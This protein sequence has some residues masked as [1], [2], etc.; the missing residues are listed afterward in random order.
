[1]K[2][3]TSVRDCGA[4]TRKS[5]RVAVIPVDASAEPDTVGLIFVIDDTAGTSDGKA[6]HIS[7]EWEGP[8]RLKVTFDPQ[9]RVFRQETVSHGVTVTYQPRVK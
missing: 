8:D 1:L 5:A 4:T 2:A 7:T 9:V 3:V 6:L